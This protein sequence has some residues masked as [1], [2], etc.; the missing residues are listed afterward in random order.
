MRVP[1]TLRLLVATVLAVASLGVAASGVFASS[2]LDT[3]TLQPNEGTDPELVG[4][5]LEAVDAS[6]PD[7]VWAVGSDV[8]GG[9]STAFSQRWDGTTW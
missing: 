9:V 1:S 4:A 6:H 2:G 8:V 5:I 7:D 3:C